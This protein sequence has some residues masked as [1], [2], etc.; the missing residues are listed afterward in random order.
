MDRI[1][2]L[3][4]FVRIAACGSFSKAAAQLEM[5]RATVSV[6]TQQLEAKLGVRLLH[7]TT[8]RVSLTQDGAALLDGATALVADMEEIERQFRPVGRGIAGRLRVDAPSRIARRLITPALPEFLHDHPEI[9]VDL[10]SSDRIIDLVENGIDCA[11]RVGELMS[12]SLVARPLGSFELINCASP[13]YLARQGTPRSP[14]DLDGHLAVD[15]V[16]STSGKADPW[17]WVENG[18]THILQVRSRVSVNNAKTYIAC[19]LAGLGMIQIPRFDVMDLLRAGDLV[20]VMPDARPSPMPVHL[21]YP[22]R[23]H[24]SRRVQAFLSWI[25]ALLVPLMLTDGSS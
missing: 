18:E 1:D 24:L 17:E 3:R 12:N 4:V 2:L 16:S 21:V 7:R 5:P 8:R 14:R 20:E 25:E 11:L 15:Y 6:A 23:K 22:H 9:Q 19:G 13:T 10:G